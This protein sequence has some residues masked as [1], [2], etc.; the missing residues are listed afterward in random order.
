VGEGVREMVGKGGR[1]GGRDVC[2]EAAGLREGGGGG[3]GKGIGEGMGEGVRH[4]RHCRSPMCM[5][6]PAAVRVKIK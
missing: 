3:G 2:G 4:M 5:L 1:E 6:P